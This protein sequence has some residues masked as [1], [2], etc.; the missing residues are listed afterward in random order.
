MIE[1]YLDLKLVQQRNVPF[2]C[3]A[4]M[5]VLDRNYRSPAEGWH[6]SQN[7]VHFCRFFNVTLWGIYRWL[8]ISLAHYLWKYSLAHWNFIHHFEKHEAWRT[9]NR[10][11]IAFWRTTRSPAFTMHKFINENLRVNIWRDNFTSDYLRVNLPSRKLSRIR[12]TYQSY[13]HWVNLPS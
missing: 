3:R 6:W 2:F 9:V 4:T 7:A 11:T 5:R 12:A 10:K 8:E 1:D 13:L